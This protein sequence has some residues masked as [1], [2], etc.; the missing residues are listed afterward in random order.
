MTTG[1]LMIIPKKVA[2]VSDGVTR[3][4]HFLSG[5]AVQDSH[6]PA[7]AEVPLKPTPADNNLSTLIATLLTVI[8]HGTSDAPVMCKHTFSELRKHLGHV[9]CKL[10][11]Y[12]QFHRQT[13]ENFE[14]Q[15]RGTLIDAGLDEVMNQLAV[16]SVEVWRRHPLLP[17]PPGGGPILK[18]PAFVQLLMLA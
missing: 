3:Q 17:P 7:P 4:L 12:L 18:P 2:G 13:L 6:Q 14:P 10:W 5:F 15:A 16:E 9:E 11:A 1:L 8:E